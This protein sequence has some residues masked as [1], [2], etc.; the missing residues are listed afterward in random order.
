ML[1]AEYQPE[2][3]TKSWMATI[4]TEPVLIA[5]QMENKTV[6]NAITKEVMQDCYEKAVKKTEKLSQAANRPVTIPR[7]E[8]SDEYD[9]D[10]IMNWDNVEKFISNHPSKNNIVRDMEKAQEDAKREAISKVHNKFPKGFVH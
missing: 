8:M 10:Y 9:L 2:I 3:G 7:K 4:Y 5:Q 6:S 1:K